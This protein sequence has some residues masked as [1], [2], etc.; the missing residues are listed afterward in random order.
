MK[1]VKSLSL[2][3]TAFILLFSGIV[4]SRN[5]GSENQSEITM[6]TIEAL[7][8][9][10][11]VQNYGPAKESPCYGGVMTRKIC[12]CEKNYPPCTESE[13]Y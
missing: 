13:C 2:I 3:T 1:T 4:L 10:E 12:M 7:A 11:V 8:L 6:A 9:T 5:Y